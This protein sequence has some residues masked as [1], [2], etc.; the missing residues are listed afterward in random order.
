[1]INNFKLIC[2]A[3]LIIPSILLA[4]TAVV[5]TNILLVK[6]KPSNQSTNNR[7]Y[8]M[9]KVIN[10][11]EKVDGLDSD[12]QWYKTPNG[13]VK[14]KYILLEDELP[15]FISKDEV[16][17]SKYALQLIVYKNTVVQSLVK[18]R[19]LLKNEDNIYLE[20]TKNVYV[21]YLVNFDSYR[22]ALNKSNKLKRIFTT[23]FIT[24]VKNDNNI[25][26]EVEENVNSKN[27]I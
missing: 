10:I 27:I 7:Y 13:Y 12:E 17:Y 22:N 16:D 26:N 6:K 8:E 11:Q 18:L 15:K 4:N 3:S 24:K 21:I 23:N 19:K 9:N 5:N 25:K 2:M 14:A 1:M 20:E